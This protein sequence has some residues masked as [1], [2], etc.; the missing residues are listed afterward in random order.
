MFDPMEPPDTRAEFERR[1]FLLGEQLR[2]GKLLFFQGAKM[3][4]LGL[5]E[6]RM[7]PNGRIDFSSINEFARLHAN[8]MA[9]LPSNLQELADGQGDGVDA[10]QTKDAIPNRARRKGAAKKGRKK[11][12]RK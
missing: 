4:E 8:M 2:N 9:H 3:S 7:L 6:V 12:R 11:K 1:F 5:R 10:S